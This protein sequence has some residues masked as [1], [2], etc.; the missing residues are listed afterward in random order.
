LL[1][2]ILIGLGIG[3][4]KNL[5]K[6]CGFKITTV[7][8]PEENKV[9]IKIK[10]NLTFLRLPQIAE[11]I[12][13]LEEGKNIEI[14]FENV[15]IADHATIDLLAGWSNRYIENKGSV[16]VDWGVL[17]NIY[18]RFGWDSLNKTYP[19]IHTNSK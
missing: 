9:L 6:L 12:E 1:E 19:K 14:I 17:K 18:P 5:Y 3:I 10:G 2:G 13:N 15:H 11:V 16:K 8:K 7:E 4:L